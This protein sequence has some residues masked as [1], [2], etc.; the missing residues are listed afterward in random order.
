ME[1][2]SE[3]FL[4]FFVSVTTSNDKTD[5]QQSLSKSSFREWFSQ[6]V[7]KKSCIKQRPVKET[8][9]LKSCIYMYREHK[10]CMV[11]IR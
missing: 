1:Y 8:T 3:P 7:K 9:S 2:D 6:V 5:R 10:V 11:A 4:C